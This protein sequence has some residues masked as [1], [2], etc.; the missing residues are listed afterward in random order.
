MKAKVTIE[1]EVEDSWYRDVKAFMDEIAPNDSLHN[2]LVAEV[3][4]VVRG[5]V[6]SW[7]G[8][9]RMISVNTN[10]TY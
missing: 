9:K 5:G 7:D 1:F 4:D 8:Y 3:S 10:L 2:Q 6:V